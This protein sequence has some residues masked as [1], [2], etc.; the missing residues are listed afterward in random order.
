MVEDKSK[1]KVPIKEG[2][3]KLTTDGDPG[4]LIATK[5]HK[6]ITYV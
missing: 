2:C 5:K 6:T 3:F 1:K 4:V